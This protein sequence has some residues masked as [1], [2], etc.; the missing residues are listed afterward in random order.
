[1]VAPTRPVE[2]L[3][4][5]LMGTVLEP[6]GGRNKAEHAAA[7]YN[8]YFRGK[9]VNS[10]VLMRAINRARKKHIQD[11]YPNARERWIAINLEVLRILN[12]EASKEVAAQI[13]DDFTRDPER[14]EVRSDAREFLDWAK[15]VGLE[16]AIISNQPRE[17]IDNFL[18]HH[19]LEDYFGDRTVSAE[20][21][22]SFK[23]R[24]RFFTQA[25]IRLSY[26]PSHVV[27]IGNSLQHDLPGAKVIRTIL[28]A[29][30]GPRPKKGR[31][32]GPLYASGMVRYVRDWAE[33]RRF[34]ERYRLVVTKA[35]FTA[36]GLALLA[37]AS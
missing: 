30:E 29:R 9:W 12:L 10:E 33:A 11:Q 3:C 34:L 37:R 19:D 6:K 13:H 22:G 16:L 21:V 1:M 25:L 20:E 4:I 36:V 17:D 31:D 32:V 5:D 18:H 2:A 8:R 14:Y 35:G 7:V 28:L 26:Q 23:P 27:H 24:R 15:R